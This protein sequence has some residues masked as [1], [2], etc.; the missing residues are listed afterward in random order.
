MYMHMSAL[1]MM[2][3]EQRQVGMKGGGGG[4]REEGRRLGGRE[5][6]ATPVL[7]NNRASGSTTGCLVSQPDCDFAYQE[8]ILLRQLEW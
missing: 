4:G 8:I 5:G 6:C 7:L 3:T 1:T 2:L